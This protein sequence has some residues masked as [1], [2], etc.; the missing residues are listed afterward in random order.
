MVKWIVDDVFDRGRV[1]L[2]RLDHL[3]PVAAAEDVI[4]PLVALV[5]GPGVATVQVPH[6][7]VEV[8][9]RGL[10]EE[11]VVVSH[12]AA[13]VRTPA[14]A[15]FDPAEDVEEDDPVAIVHHDR[16]V[17]VATDPDVVVRAGLE[18]TEGA[19]HRSKVAA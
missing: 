7:L 4:L 1:L 15:P 11:V 18:V 16:R 10:D 8:R 6:S 9:L 13:H 5:E 19:S 14:V 3:R 17:V 2:V 12:Q